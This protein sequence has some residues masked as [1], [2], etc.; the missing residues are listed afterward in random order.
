MINREQKLE[1]TL[2]IIKTVVKYSASLK[3]TETPVLENTVLALIE[4]GLKEK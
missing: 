3:Q 1:Q 2:R 4:K